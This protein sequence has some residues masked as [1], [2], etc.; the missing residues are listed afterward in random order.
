MGIIRT[1]S[2]LITLP[3][4][5][6]RFKYL[7]LN[8]K[9]G[10]ETFGF[11]RYLNQIFYNSEEWKSIRDFVI[12]RDGGCDLGI[13]DREIYT[14]ILVHHMNPIRQEDILRRSKFLLDPEFLISTMKSTH[15]AIHYGDENLLILEPI[16]RTQNDTCPWRR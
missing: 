14:R 5:E 12:I 11:D 16:E 13:P 2:E 9:V 4:F 7:Q 1:Y 8:G 15:D 6:E 3:T 10:E